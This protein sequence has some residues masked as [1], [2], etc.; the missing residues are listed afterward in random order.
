VAVPRF[1]NP[2]APRPGPGPAAPVRPGRAD[3]YI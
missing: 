1:P 3:G 2:R